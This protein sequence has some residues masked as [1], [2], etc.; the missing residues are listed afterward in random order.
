MALELQ[1]WDLPMRAGLVEA[2]QPEVLDPAAGFSRVE[3]LLQ[4]KTAALVKRPG[5]RRLSPLLLDGTTLP[6]AIRLAA[7]K[8]GVLAIDGEYLYARSDTVNRWVRRDHVPSVGATRS[9][10]VQPGAGFEPCYEMVAV[11]NLRVVTYATT[12]GL[13]GILQIHTISAIVLDGATGATVRGPDLVATSAAGAEFFVHKLIACGNN[14]ICVYDPRNAPGLEQ[15]IARGLNVTNAATISAGWAVPAAVTVLGEYIPLGSAFASAWDVCAMSDR[16]FLSFNA[17][18]VP[19]TPIRT[20]ANNPTTPFARIDTADNG[21]EGVTIAN[22]VAEGDTLWIA[23][24]QNTSQVSVR[25]IGLDPTNLAATLATA[26]I[27]STAT[28]MPFAVYKGLA[29]QPTTAGSGMVFSCPDMQGG[30]FAEVYA[31]R[32]TT[33]LGA[34]VTDGA[35]R[36]YRNFAMFTKPWRTSG[37]VYMGLILACGFVAFTV[38][39]RWP[40]QFVVDMTDEED[41]LRVVANLAP[42]LVSIS[43][44]GAVVQPHGVAVAGSSVEYLLPI[45]H[46]AASSGLEIVMVDHAATSRWQPVD[47]ADAVHMSA[48]C[49]S[50]FDGVRVAE[51]N[52]LRPGQMVAAAPFAAVSGLALG[53]YF[54]TCVYEQIDAAGNLHQSE[55]ALPQSV[56]VGAG[57]PPPA[58]VILSLIRLIPTTRQDAE[59]NTNPVRVAIYRTAPNGGTYYRLATVDNQPGGVNLTYTD[60]ITDVT[61]GALLYTQ[62]GTRGTALPHRAPPSL[63][64][65]VQ[66]G[67]SLAGIADNGAIWFSGAHVPGEGAWWNPLMSVTIEDANR[68]VAL[69]SFDGRLYVFMRSR[70]WVIDGPGY[71]DNGTGGYSPPQRLGV[72]SGCVEPRSVV[73]TPWGTF[74][75]SDRGLELLT[76]TGEVQWIGEVVRDRL[77]AFPVVTGATHNPDTDQVVFSCATTEASTSGVLLALD[78]ATST[79]STYDYPSNAGAAT[80]PRSVVTALRGG[81]PE[82]H[83]IDGAEGESIAY[84]DATIGYDEIAAANV[85]ADGVL[86]TAWIKL[87]GLQGYQRVWRILLLLRRITD[88]ALTVELAFDY[89]DTYTETFTWTAAEIAALPRE[90]AEVRPRR[91]KCQAVRVR[92][93]DAAG[94][95]LGSGRGSIVLGCRV[96]YGVKR[97]T[98]LSVAHR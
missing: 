41:T 78:L 81:A 33:T 22:A 83:W 66:H 51:M 5:T 93:T 76:R 91:Q 8:D 86:E 24:C 49:A 11:G 54:Y 31:R 23:W 27:I 53:T 9:V 2:Q 71:A 48:G 10:G 87:A 14:V 97:K 52:F 12:N 50:Y 39:G 46:A 36:Q 17:T 70:I 57:L 20:V 74:F 3:N 47:F 69:A 65:L 67:D 85:W 95:T 64:F 44:A 25:V 72:A 32:F 92:V 98:A 29:I 89:S 45:R 61:T 88:H 90:Q 42:G 28:T 1:Y 77:A 6:N 56:T 68:P 79:W 18:G 80:A 62:P 34:C 38:P 37:R 58:S 7:S 43:E 16:W 21:I 55:P 30:L 73:M 84:D 59:D 63:S 94:G 13:A 4:D 40:C 60:E 96:A 75:Q 19:P 26:A 35:D 82:L 15:I